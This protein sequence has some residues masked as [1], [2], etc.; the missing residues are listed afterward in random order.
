MTRRLLVAVDDSEPASA[1]L[2]H[3]LRL[4]PEDDIVAIHVTDSL[5]ESYGGRDGSDEIFDWVRETATEHG[6]SVETVVESGDTAET[7]VRFATENG[8]DQL[9]LGSHGRSGVSRM[10]LGSVAET[11]VRNSPIPVTVVR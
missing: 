4:F 10:L 8:I 11:V 5:E 1:A 3:V 2:D 9:F 7:V 6:A